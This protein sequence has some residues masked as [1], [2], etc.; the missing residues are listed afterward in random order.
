MAK[1]QVHWNE[2]NTHEP[3]KAAAFFAETLGWTIE[4]VER[5][6]LPPYRVAKVGD[7]MVAGVFDLA[8]LYPESPDIPAQWITY[9]EVEDADAQVETVREAGGKIIRE[10]F[11][12]PYVGRFVIL[13]DSVGAVCGFIQPDPS[14]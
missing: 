6:P 2:L 9:F 10:P 1:G 11:D 5:G 12:V 13:H 7:A 8:E 4:T 3:A 14:E